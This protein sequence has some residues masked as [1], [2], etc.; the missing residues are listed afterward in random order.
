MLRSGCRG[1]GP[2]ILRARG[3]AGRVMDIGDDHSPPVSRA[4]G[5][6]RM[7]AALRQ[8]ELVGFPRVRE[9]SGW[10]TGS[11]KSLCSRRRLRPR[12]PVRTAHDPTPP[13]RARANAK[14]RPRGRPACLCGSF[15]SGLA[16]AMGVRRRPSG[17][18][19]ALSRAPAVDHGRQLFRDNGARKILRFVPRAI[20]RAV[21]GLGGRADNRSSPR[22]P[23]FL[24][25]SPRRRPPRPSV[26]LPGSA[27]RRPGPAGQAGRSRAS[28]PPPGAS[29]PAPAGTR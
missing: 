29:P 10:R 9:C 25:E 18:E 6:V 16:N 27:R 13:P 22:A 7:G 8:I 4:S 1:E 17:L 2:P 28:R 26:P 20:K 11:V 24:R 23:A 14:G 12:A 21:H 3:D 19:G 5:D 15:T